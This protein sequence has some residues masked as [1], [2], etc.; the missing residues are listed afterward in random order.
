MLL[1]SGRRRLFDIS[2]CSPHLTLIQ[3]QGTGFCPCSSQS[4]APHDYDPNEATETEH[5]EEYASM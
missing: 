1:S 5:L 3:R 2:K 4:N